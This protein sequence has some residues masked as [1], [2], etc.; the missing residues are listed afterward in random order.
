MT[1]KQIGMPVFTT[2]AIAMAST[3]N[4]TAVVVPNAL[5]GVEGGTNN[6]FPFGF[7]TAYAPSMRYQ[8][9]YASSQFAAFNPG[10]E[11]ISAI[12]FRSDAYAF[13]RSF[14]T[15]PAAQIKLSTIAAGPDGLSTTFASNIGANETTVFGPAPL[16]LSSAY[17][18]PGGTLAPFDIV[19]PLTTPFFY[20][21]AAGNLLLDIR[22]LFPGNTHAPFDAEDAADSVSRVYSLNVISPTGIAD[23]FGLVTK[24][25]T[26]IPEPS[27]FALAATSLLAL[28]A[29]RRRR[30]VQH[31]AS[32]SLFGDM[33]HRRIRTLKA[34]QSSA[35]D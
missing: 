7:D 33:R 35:A 12:A 22:N 1:L 13:A 23:T 14:S 30:P 2:I 19:I 34:P 16:S 20:N 32:G 9:V 11:Y 15:S 10:G 29:T 25:I 24:F 27:A 5:A 18:G 6:V 31:D 28:S 4:A 21:P 8:Q 26:A 3:A 17:A